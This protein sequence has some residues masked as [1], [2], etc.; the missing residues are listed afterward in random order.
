MQAPEQNQLVTVGSLGNNKIQDC[1]MSVW[2]D[3]LQQWQP[4]EEHESH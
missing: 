1:D 3:T 2:Q 4:K